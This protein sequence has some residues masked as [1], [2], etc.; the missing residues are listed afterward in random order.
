MFSVVIVVGFLFSMVWTV[1]PAAA[2]WY[3]S[4][5]FMAARSAKAQL[6]ALPFNSTQAAM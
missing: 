6:E 1:S 3:A 4:L 5:R 2:F